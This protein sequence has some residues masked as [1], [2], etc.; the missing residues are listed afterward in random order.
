MKLFQSLRFRILMSC[1]GLALSINV[2]HSHL[3][4]LAEEESS[5]DIFNWHLANHAAFYFSA[6]QAGLTDI[7]ESSQLPFPGIMMLANDQKFMQS[8]PGCNPQNSD[9]TFPERITDWSLLRH[10]DDE[11]HSTVKIHEIVCGDSRFHIAAFP[12]T[13]AE[14]FFVAADITSFNPDETRDDDDHFIESAM[15][16][17]FSLI[18]ALLLGIYLTRRAVQPLSQLQEDVHQTDISN[19][20]HLK[21]TYYPDEVGQLA[22]HINHLLN[23]IREFVI[24]EK[25]FSRDASHELRTPLTSSK[26]A[27]E[28]ALSLPQGQEPEMQRLL[29]RINRANNDMT[30]LIKTFLVLGKEDISM[31][32]ESDVNLHQ[33]TDNICHNHNYCLAKD[34]VTVSNDIAADVNLRIQE[35][36]LIIVLSN[37]I[38]NAFQHT[39]SGNIK[40]SYNNYRLLVTNTKSDQQIAHSSSSMESYGFGLQIVERICSVIDWQF[41]LSQTKDASFTA[42]LNLKP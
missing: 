37:M 21:S 30:H 32:A 17:L 39:E 23:R 38:R 40:I 1:L 20:S 5:D 16:S 41:E 31:E 8:L 19:A 13:D 29:Q 33:L 15:M 10:T 22:S 36:L 42:Q 6:Y 12:A 26:M 7:H 27:T 25:Q 28:L 34:T 3:I 24:R 14:T 9:G 35:Q 4:S 11:S 18:S 2:L